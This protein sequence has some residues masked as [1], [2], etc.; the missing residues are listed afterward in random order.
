MRFINE[1]RELIGER[2]ADVQTLLK[3][4]Q[5][6][7]SGVFASLAAFVTLLF[8]A[9]GVFSELEDALNIMWDVKSQTSAGFKGMIRQRFFCLVW[10]C[11]LAFSCWSC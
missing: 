2:G 5:K 11:L 1:A 3:N 4:A 7:A 9:S 10:S 6:P 8:G